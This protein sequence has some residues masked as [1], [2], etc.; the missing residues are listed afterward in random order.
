[1]ASHKISEHF[2]RHEFACHCGCGFD[3]ADVELVTVLEDVRTRFG[4]KVRI[5]SG[6]RCPK[7]NM[8]VGGSP[9]SQHKLGKAGDIEVEGV[10][11]RSV[12]DYLEHKY[13]N[14]YGIGRYNGRTHLDVR[15][16]RAR[17]DRR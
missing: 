12:A 9:K 2:S 16:H 15:L 11:A 3:V 14:T 5:N 13:P 7:H 4:A 10:P 8:D 1:M 6:A 17:W